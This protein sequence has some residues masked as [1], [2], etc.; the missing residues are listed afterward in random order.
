MRFDP[1]IHGVPRISQLPFGA[2]GKFQLA[3]RKLLVCSLPRIALP[4]LLFRKRATVAAERLRLYSASRSRWVSMFSRKFCSLRLSRVRPAS[5]AGG[6]AVH[7]SSRSAFVFWDGYG[8]TYYAATKTQL[9]A[10]PGSRLG[11]TLRGV[12][13]GLPLRC[14]RGLTLRPTTRVGVPRRVVAIATGLRPYYY[15]NCPLRVKNYFRIIFE[16]AV[17]YSSVSSLFTKHPC[18]L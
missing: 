18:K 11:I 14:G 15:R 4:F 8:V 9:I 2:G 5:G 16:T 7:S 10:S 3:N 1:C 6:G 13:V 12:R 17:T